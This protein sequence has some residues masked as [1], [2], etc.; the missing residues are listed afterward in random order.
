MRNITL[1]IAIFFFLPYTIFA[2]VNFSSGIANGLYSNSRHSVNEDIAPV[3]LHNPIFKYE[4]GEILFQWDNLV[5]P[6]AKE[7]IYEFEVR[8]EDRLVLSIKTNKNSIK[9]G[10]EIYDKIKPDVVYRA[11][12]NTRITDD[13]KSWVLYGDYLAIPFVYEPNC[14]PP[15]NA[16][17]TQQE[18]DTYI[19]NWDGY[20]AIP[21]VV[22]YRLRYKSELDA[23]WLLISLSEGT[24][25]QISELVKFDIVEMQKVCY[26][27]NQYP[28]YS[29]WVNVAYNVSSKI[30]LPSFDCGSPY[31]YPT[32]NCDSANLLTNPLQNVDI[33]Y[34]GGFPIEVT[35]ISHD[36]FTPL[37][38]NAENEGPVLVWTGTGDIPLPFGIDK[39]IS[40]EFESIVLNK[41]NEVCSSGRYIRPISDTIPNLPDLS[42]SNGY[43]N[44]Q[45]CLPPPSVA[46][47]DSNGIHSVTGL[48]WDPYGFG[49]TGK[50]VKQPP[51]VGYLPGFPMDTTGTY[52]PNGFNSEGIH[53]LTGT[54]YNPSGCGRDGVDSLG[55][56]CTP[57]IPPYS[58]MDNS[59]TVA[60]TEAGLSYVSQ[61]Q[62]SLS[63]IILR[64]L[65][66]LNGINTLNLN[67]KDAVCDSIRTEMLVN[68]SSSGVNADFLFGADDEYFNEGMHLNFSSEPQPM[69][70]VSLMPGL[71]NNAIVQLEL[72][73]ID[74]Y[75][76]DKEYYTYV[77]MRDVIELLMGSNLLEVKGT[78]L[79][80]I[81]RLP[82]SKIT[83]FINDHS[84]FLVWLTDQL[85]LEI[86]YEYIAQHGSGISSLDRNN[87]YEQH[88]ERFNN[89]FPS[90]S[91]S[92][93]SGYIASSDF[94]ADIF[95]DAVTT[96][97]QDLQFEY[98]QGFREVGGIHRA[99]Y[100][101]KIVNNRNSF[102]LTTVANPTYQPIDIVNVGEDGNVFRIYIDN[103][104]FIN[105]GPAK[106]D[107]TIVVDVPFSGQRIV[108]EALDVPFTPHGLLASEGIKLS[109]VNDVPIRISNN[110]KMVFKKGEN[111]YVSMNCLG[112]AGMGV[113]AEVEI[114]RNIVKPLDRITDKIMPDPEL[115]KG[116]FITIMPSLSSLYVQFS[117][118]PFV[119]TGAEDVKWY[120][121]T[122]TLDL[123]EVISPVGTPPAGYNTQLAGPG[124]FSPLWKGFYA[125]S[126]QVSLP[127]K[128]RKD[129]APLLVGVHNLMIDPMGVSCAINV[130][131][132][133]PLNEGNADGWALSLEKFE[134]TILMSNVSKAEFSGKLHI[135]LFRDSTNTSDTLKP[136]DCFNYVASI[137]PQQAYLFT[138]TQQNGV[139]YAADIWKAGSIALNASSIQ[140][141]Y[142]ADS[143]HI[144][145][146]LSGGLTISSRVS[147]HVNVNIPPLT[148]QNL[149]ISNR[150]PYFSP[151]V[152]G[153]PITLGAKFAGFEIGFKNIGMVQTVD[154]EPMLNFDV[155]IN[156]SD[157]TSKLKATVGFGLVGELTY[158][159]G[160]QRWK[161][162]KLKVQDIDI[163]GS[164]PGVDYVR[165]FARFFEGDS[166]FGTGFRG[167]L[168][169]KFKMMGEVQ[170]VGQFGRMES[171]KYFM[172]DALY[173][174]QPGNGVNLAG[175]FE[176]RGGGGG[177]YYHMARPLHAINFGGCGVPISPQLGV[178]LSGI[179]YRPTDTVGLGIKLTLV[180]AT[181]GLD[182]AFNMNV[183]LEF[184]FSTNRSLE[185]IWLGGNAK[186]MAPIDM[187][188]LPTFLKNQLPN[189]NAAVKANVDIAVDFS[190]NTLDG[191]LETYMNIAGVLR[192]GDTTV[193]DRVCYAKIW[194]KSEDEWYLKIGGTG[195]GEGSLPRMSI[196]AV[197]P[198]MK[199]PLFTFSAYMQIGKDLDPLPPLPEDILEAAQRAADK[200]GSEFIRSTPMIEGD[201]FI[202]GVD[203][204][205][206]G[207]F[208]FLALYADMSA[209]MGFDVGILKSNT[210][211]LCN[212][213]A[214]GVNGWYASGQIYSSIAVDMGLE[215]KVYGIKK[216][217]SIINGYVFAALEAR[218]PNPFWAQGFIDYE[219]SF[220]NGLIEGGDSFDFQVGEL[221]QFTQQGSIAEVPIILDVN[222][223][224]G[225]LNKPVYWTPMVTFNFP[226]NETFNFKELTGDES[227]FHISLD[228]AK[229]Y[230][231]GYEIPVKDYVW[232]ADKKKLTIKPSNFLPGKDTIHILVSVHVDSNGI[233]ID[234]E[235]YEGWFVTGEGIRAI[236]PGN[237]KGSYPMDGQYNFYRNELAN[238][239]G[240]IQLDRG[241]PDVFLTENEFI[242][243]VRF[244]KSNGACHFEKLQ[245]TP[246]QFWSNKIEFPLPTD[247][248]FESGEI[249][250]MQIVDYPKS[251]PA[252][253]ADFNGPAPCICNGCITPVVIPPS[254]PFGG[255]LASTLPNYG[256]DSPAPTP[257]VLPPAT[258]STSAQRIV[259]SAYFRV[260]QYLRF[261][262]KMA[263][264]EGVAPKP[265]KNTTVY[266]PD[267]QV[268]VPIEKS[269]SIP[270]GIEPFDWCDRRCMDKQIYL[271]STFFPVPLPNDHWMTGV[272]SFYSFPVYNPGKTFNMPGGGAFYTG[273]TLGVPT[274]EKSLNFSW[275][276][277]SDLRIEK[278]HWISGL[279]ATFAGAQ[280]MTIF[281]VGSLVE[282]ATTL[283]NSL[284]DYQNLYESTMREQMDCTD[285][286]PI[287]S[288]NHP[289][290]TNP[291]A[292][293]IFFILRCSPNTATGGVKSYPLR[294]AYQLPGTAQSTGDYFILINH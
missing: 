160:T 90:K 132:I 172:I 235:R 278:N 72:Q 27:R 276:N 98:G 222:P 43:G 146:R 56:P 155:H 207:Y 229:L 78:I 102:A 227:S 24:Q 106:M 169:A 206:G 286:I 202:F 25:Y 134:L 99:F 209:H 128:F 125:R 16:R 126:I 218:M 111:T 129:Q 228:T 248:Y 237:V 196:I 181:T 133:L 259:Y 79:E 118:T 184:Q 127:R 46:Q 151:G 179:P 5:L 131:N 153:F 200:E 124:G 112:F 173:C 159:N 201:G 8:E 30:T 57:Q 87:I 217:F 145:A 147:D 148:F 249:Y 212:G 252:W 47:F 223:S 68:V 81:K 152:W 84:Y 107:A 83:Q 182:E 166:I 136:K 254:P 20:P 121:D 176:I 108:F 19:V 89:S 195:I 74:L 31:N 260:S 41:D 267:D 198:G 236:A 93:P 156:I 80:K 264:F 199:Q 221:C 2:Q 18:D 187:S 120:I 85:K 54:M 256:D 282:G 114:C 64:I 142:V 143:F 163:N 52:D 22:E 292:F 123:S 265:P 289:D 45:I 203:V 26:W 58:W 66:G 38:S 193:A 135:P 270:V 281:A 245:F 183:S 154:K 119:V 105:E 7:I 263:A 268:T 191:V 67:N 69:A 39:Y 61:I 150:F 170:V 233:T 6:S 113:E 287:C 4:A 86:S 230:W 71:R 14:T 188:T 115:V 49:P 48:P 77:Y 94:S 226:V 3:K 95:Q 171:Y 13:D 161:Y 168:A 63:N 73:H 285:E 100:H 17:I 62:D 75:K 210:P 88:E 284:S 288:C 232:N 240:Y 158:V 82:E 164:F 21:G 1:N 29:E 204:T 23:D 272:N 231:R 40:V 34:I 97:L 10:E 138:V 271:T 9:L 139:S 59:G 224:Q 219:Y 211:M 258:N 167:G 238:G 216:R 277:N 220:L 32:I 12:V 33:I 262:D 53:A 208:K 101:E 60:P 110:A 140:M 247:G 51:Y 242:K 70:Q 251:D 11:S 294:F 243:V 180:V 157:D 149:E 137:L 103:I 241:Q 91:Y 190:N 250:E 65:T 37:K 279:P 246:D 293:N 144:V 266:Q 280:Q 244:R 186:L 274:P 215:V 177:A 178:S 214:F 96:T 117:V 253:G 141:S 44:A 194:V 175:A 109:L 257:P 174:A 50:Y 290:F 92:G 185:K 189:T 255:M 275:A 165:G 15:Q 28:I 104:E 261:A 213:H 205:M 162:R 234:R 42:P 35:S 122:I 291:F 55:Q 239:K 273:P 225:T 116:R 269:F 130:S 76:C 197:V 283:Q 192:G 36:T